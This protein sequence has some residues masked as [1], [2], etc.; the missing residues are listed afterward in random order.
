M[1]RV[2]MGHETDV[3]HKRHRQ[4]PSAQ[5]NIPEVQAQ[6]HNTQDPPWHHAPERLVRLVRQVEV[7]PC[8]A[9]VLRADDDV[10]T[11]R[12]DGHTRHGAAAAEQL[13]GQSL[14]GKQG[15]G[16]V[17]GM[18]EG[19]KVE[20]GSPSWLLHKPPCFVTPHLL[21]LTQLCQNTCPSSSALSANAPT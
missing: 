4:T 14:K 18:V 7:K 17:E 12:V 6:H 3:H 5:K 9:L 11:A 13:L 1:H 19:K 8:E 10:I 16:K 20:L 15:A 21:L 2:S